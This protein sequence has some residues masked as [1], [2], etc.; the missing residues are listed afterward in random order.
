MGAED[1]V[2]FEEPEPRHFIVPVDT[3]LCA[4]HP[5]PP[6]R[7]SGI[8]QSALLSS[9]LLCLPALLCSA[10]P[11]CSALLCFLLTSSARDAL[12]Q[13]GNTVRHRVHASY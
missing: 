4:A 13:L 9:T 8:S 3:G 2:G 10:L 5:P 12:T 11:P 6:G 1:K 7:S